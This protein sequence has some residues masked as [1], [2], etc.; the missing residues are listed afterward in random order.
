MS[1]TKEAIIIAT[2]QLFAERGY[3]NVTLRDV[4][5]ECGISPGNLSYHFHTKEDLVTE[6][7][8]EVYEELNESLALSTD[9]TVKD[10]LDRFRELEE[11]SQRNSFYF[12]NMF[13]LGEN[14]PSIRQFQERF[15]EH[16][17]Y[18]YM[19]SFSSMVKAGLL[20]EDIPDEQY[21]SLAVR[22]IMVT[23]S[24]TFNIASTDEGEIVKTDLSHALSDCI[25][26]YLTARG[27]EDWDAYFS[28]E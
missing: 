22:V 19:R 13:V 21:R 3:E 26:P 24:W 6:V 4:A 10:L 18:Y 14:F 28:A 17:F 7:M 11:T 23:I 15:R 9:E 2:K 5:A 25:Y 20:R 1:T 8:G 27:L 16:M 12:R